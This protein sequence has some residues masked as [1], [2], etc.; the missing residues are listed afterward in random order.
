LRRS[1]LDFSPFFKFEILRNLLLL[2][3]LELLFCFD[4][5]DD[6]SAAYPIVDIAPPL[7]LAV[8]WP[9]KVLKLWTE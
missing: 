5:D 9:F 1:L 4:N 7:E 8:P 3:L 6:G 2:S